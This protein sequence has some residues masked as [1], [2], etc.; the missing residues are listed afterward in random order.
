MPNQVFF[1]TLG[2]ETN[3]F[4]PIPAGWNVWRDTLLRRRSDK[5]PTA[6]RNQG[7]LAPLWQ[8]CDERGWTLTPGLQAFASPSGV[9]PAPVWRALRDELLA[10][11]AAAAPVDAVLL[12]LHGAMIADGCEDCE[13]ELLT[14]VRAEVGT[15]VPVGA[16]LDLHCHL[17]PTMLRQAD[18]LFGYREYPHVDT[19]TRLAELLGALIDTA[20]RRISPSMALA[21]CAMVGMFPTTAP[22]T[23]AL[24]RRFREAS[25]DSGM[26]DVWLAHGFPWGDVPELGMR[27]LAIADGDQER[28]RACAL[29]LAAACFELREAITVVPETL[30]ATLDSALSEP[31]GPVVIADTADNTG[32]G[33]PGDSTF[34]LEALLDRGVASAA[35]GP[36]YDPGAVR[37]CQDAGIGARL[38]LRVG[39]KLAPESGCPLDVRAEVI[40]LSDRVVQRLNG[41]PAQLGACAGI[42]V[43]LDGER[44]GPWV[45]LASNRVQAGSPELFTELGIDPT[46]CQVVVVKST[47]HFHA[48]FAPIAQRILYAGEPG[49][50]HGDPRRIPYRHAPSAAL[51][52]LNP[53]ARPRGL[54]T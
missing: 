3:S 10:D 36:L 9:T 51:W 5:R 2:T 21:D 28:A 8:I 44:P 14:A 41:A 49:A 11:I 38:G 26:I 15:A 25:A 22:A 53:D 45:V 30:D 33:A 4:S 32:G 40:G 48:G 23:A 7:H 50:L 6:H 43:L 46:A 17:T 39:G 52:P 16:L 1:A 13:G 34:F 35:L 18:L 27:V 47:Q 24:V 31:R 42:R 20:A 19:Y 37:I 54:L 29:E 12:H